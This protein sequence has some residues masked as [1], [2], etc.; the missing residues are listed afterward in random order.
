MPSLQDLV[1]TEVN[2]SSQLAGMTVL[3][4]STQPAGT[5]GQFAPSATPTTSTQPTVAPEPTVG[6]TLEGIKTQA[7]VIQAELDKRKALEGLTYDTTKNPYDSA[8]VPIDEKAIARQQMKLFQKEIDATNRVYQDILNKERLAG[9]GRLGTQTAMAARGGLLGSD[10]GEA[11]RQTQM[12]ANSEVERSIQNERLAKIGTIMGTMRKAVAD[13]IAAKRLARTQDAETYVKYLAAGKERKVE[14]ARIA[15]NALL[16][17]GID[18]KT[19]TPEELSAIGKEANLS[20]NDILAEYN[21]LKSGK[22]EADLKTRK[23]EAEINK[24][25]ADI[26]SG[27]L[28]TI[29]EGT[30]LY[31]TETGETFKNPKTY[32]PGTGSGSSL[33]LTGDGKRTLLGGGWSEGE[34][35]TL[36]DGVKEYGLQEVIAKEKANGAT[37]SQI[38]SLEKAYKSGGDETNNFLSEDYFKQLFGEDGLKSAAKEAGTVTGGDDWIPFNE[39]GDTSSYLTKLMSTV[40]LY[41]QAGYT[42]QEILKLMQ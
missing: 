20:A 6:Q 18:P 26:A 23:T 2:K 33:D 37:S 3:P 42:D 22:E 7:A 17:S 35:G 28:K 9:Q 34:I 38:A 21:S 4:G 32:A 31:N 29:G 1:D 15:A 16:D 24:I 14:N 12:S 30:M 5:T 27:K 19:L 36:Q 25:D 40:E 11:Q 39:A 8:I 41:R 13:E 10:F